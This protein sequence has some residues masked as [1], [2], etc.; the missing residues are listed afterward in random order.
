MSE[1]TG[2]DKIGR[3]AAA[4]MDQIQEVLGDEGGRV[5]DV[6]ISAELS[7]PTD[8][9]EDCRVIVKC[10]AESPIYQRGLATA[11]LHVVS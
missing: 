4:L 3:I 1:V 5:E 11:A 10:S 7:V 9:G 6:M 2:T 8:D